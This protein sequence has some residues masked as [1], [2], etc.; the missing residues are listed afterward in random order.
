MA[1]ISLFLLLL[2]LVQV[3]DAQQGTP[4]ISLGA[5]LY[6]NNNSHWLSNS[7]QFAFGFYRQGNGLAVG[8]W[9]E[10]TNPKTIIWTA[11]L[12]AA[13]Q[14]PLP[15]D[16][17]LI[18]SD[19]GVCLIFPDNPYL[20][21]IS[22]SSQPAVRASMLDSGNFV[23]YN[24][25][26]IIWQ[27]FDVPTNTILSGQRLL[28]GKKAHLLDLEHKSHKRKVSSDHAERW[29]PGFSTQMVHLH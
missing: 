12:D 28:A 18:L 19:Q 6:P 4:N 10:K 1:A 26:D 3:A 17:Q 20:I 7:G 15:N 21:P 27:T 22:N 11:N 5:S 8:I 25:S 23:L 16:A 2:L 9:F 13:E 29:E 14:E 24:D